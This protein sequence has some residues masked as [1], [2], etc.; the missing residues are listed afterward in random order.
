MILR[1]LL[2]LAFVA[3]VLG[4]SAP[5]PAAAPRQVTIASTRV[6]VGDVLPDADPAIASLD[7]GPAPVAGGTRVVTRDEIVAAIDA[8]QLPAPRVVPQAVRVLRK[9]RR[10]EPSE[11]DALVRGAIAA[12]SPKHGVSLE[13]VRLDHAVDVAEGWTHVE[14]DAPRA[15]KKAGPFSTTAVVSFL[16]ADREPLARLAVPVSFAV[17]AEGAVYDAPRGSSLTLV[18]SRTLVEVRVPAAASVDADV[19]DTLPV[20]IRLSGRTMRARLVSKDEAVA[21][22]APR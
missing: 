15:P 12:K 1:P 13:A 8:R 19:G 9:T 5:S 3:A 22:E 7:L 18:I 10:L 11:V 21:V 14:V 2:S 17:S 16:N 20:Q 6:H 4:V